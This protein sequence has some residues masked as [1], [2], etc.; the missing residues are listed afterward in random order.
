MFWPRGDLIN[1]H[2]CVQIW[3]LF[4]CVC[5]S[6]SDSNT[7][8]KCNAGLTL[9]YLQFIKGSRLTELQAKLP[10][11]KNNHTIKQNKQTKKDFNLVQERPLWI[12][13]LL[14]FHLPLWLWQGY[15]KE[16]Q[17]RWCFEIRPVPLGSTTGCQCPISERS[18]RSSNEIALSLVY[19]KTHLSWN[20]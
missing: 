11:M 6:Y 17:L 9:F 20:A 15:W 19:Y 13:A 5:V 4:F 18:L 16:R 7:G 2:F 8:N 1:G 14:C 3:L 12:F 10:L